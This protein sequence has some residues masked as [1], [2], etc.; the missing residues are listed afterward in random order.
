[1]RN[2]F[3]FIC[4]SSICLITIYAQ[5]EPNQKKTFQPEL[6]N[7]ALPETIYESSGL[8]YYNNLLWTINDGGNA[9]CL[10]GYNIELKNVVRQVCLK[11]VQNLDWE[12][13]S[14]DER[15]VYI[16]DIGNNKG[17]RNLFTIYR[18]DKKNLDGASK[19]I[20]PEVITFSYK[21]YTSKKFS[22]FTQ[23]DAEAIVFINDTIV[24]FNKNWQDTYCYIYFIPAKKGHYEIIPAE[25]I[26]LDGL[27]TDASYNKATR[28]LVL[29]GYSDIYPFVYHFKK[30]Q[31]N[32]LNLRN[33]KLYNFQKLLG[34]QVEG[35]TFI[36]D[37]TIMFTSEY[38]PLRKGE[39]Y[40]LYIQ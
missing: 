34:A 38:S 5:N 35:V 39:L 31:I 14:M 21:K 4:I 3:F 27:V 16:A 23:W 33:A 30:F 11:N 13:L 15:N 22:I 2:I 26:Y 18:I 29:V 10:Y 12:A 37:T 32:K 40:K 9:P 6:I 8:L 20:E 19:E 1:M 36:N 17:W 25:R 24:L 7:E 28:S